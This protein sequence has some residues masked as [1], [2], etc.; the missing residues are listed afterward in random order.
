MHKLC[1][2]IVPK[3]LNDDQKLQ[4]MHVCKDIL[5]NVV[6]NPDLL[7]K[8]ITGDK[9]WIFERNPETNRQ[10]LHWKSPQSPRIKKVRPSKSKIKLMLKAFFDVRGMIHYELLPQGQTVNHPAYKEILQRLLRSVREKRRD[11]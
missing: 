7:K 2:E 6:S 10:S 4:R 3:L 11:L 5:E 1:A 9:A 8:V